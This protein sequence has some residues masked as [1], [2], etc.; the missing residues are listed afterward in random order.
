MKKYLFLLLIPFS[1]L[2]CKPVVSSSGNTGTTP[3]ASFDNPPGKIYF[4][5][6]GGMMNKDFKGTFDKWKI[7]KYNVPGGDYSKIEAEIEVDIA[8]VNVNPD[9]LENHLRADDYLDAVGFPSAIIK[10]KGAQQPRGKDTWSANATVSIKGMLNENVAIDFEVLE[11]KP[12]IIKGA[13]S[14]FRKDYKVGDM[15]SEK[16]KNKVPIEFEFTAPM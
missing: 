2:A 5:G 10:I 16:V 8:S 13:T 15:E 4:T 9:G 1:I 14:L 6:S 3:D 11:S 12:T 7:N